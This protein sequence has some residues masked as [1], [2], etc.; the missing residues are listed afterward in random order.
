[1]GRKKFLQY[2]VIKGIKKY[3]VR[4]SDGW[5]IAATGK[6]TKAQLKRLQRLVDQA[7]LAIKT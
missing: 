5:V 4:S 2:D 1:M 3:G 6:D 7:N